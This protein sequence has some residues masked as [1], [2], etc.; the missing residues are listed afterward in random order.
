MKKNKKLLI[1]L[2]IA[3]VVVIGGILIYK[4][5]NNARLD[6]FYNDL[7]TLGDKVSYYY[8]EYG[9]IPVK[10]EYTGTENFKAQ[11][12]ESDSNNNYIID[13]NS[14]EEKKKKNEVTG[15]GEDVYI[16]NDISHTIYYAKG[17]SVEGKMYYT[18]PK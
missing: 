3:V 16:I 14:L 9:G 2:I 15:E 12:N 6:S 13:T 5:V 7:K 17:I 1:G 11:K 4:G 8:D 10:E 18:L